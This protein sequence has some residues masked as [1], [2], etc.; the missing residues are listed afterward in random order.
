MT[1]IVIY[2][3]VP[4]LALF[5][6]WVVRTAKDGHPDV[7]GHERW[8]Y[9]Y[10]LAVIALIVFA[11][12]RVDVGTDYPMYE[13]FFR[14][15]DPTHFSYFFHNSPEEPGFTTGVLWLKMFFSSPQVLFLVTS[16][17]TVGC[18]ALA[19]RRLSVHFVASLTLFVLLG[20]YVAPFNILR[21]GLAVSLT[22]LAY[23]YM[24]KGKGRWLGLNVLA[25]LMH[26]SAILAAV[27]QVLLRRVRPTWFLYGAMLFV[28]VA[29]AVLVHVA[30]SAFSFLS[31][32]NDRYLSYLQDHPSGIGTYLY[33]LSRFILVALLLV[34]R[35]RNGEIDRYIVLAMVGVCLLI[36][37]T[38]AVAI[39]RLELYFSIYLVVALPRAARELPRPSR[40]L[41]ISGVMAMVTVFYIAYL[42]KFGNLVPYHFDWALVGLPSWVPGS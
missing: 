3:L 7:E 26:S 37:G 27:L 33:L 24:D 11:G 22:F 9:S 39:G 28:S 21:Q 15:V 13:S 19:I 25:A 20:F 35:P 4:L 18:A 16:L 29:L 31:I 14:Q 42:T 36:L 34:Y 30:P 23:S 10:I 2:L 41:V 12:A 32:F 8:R 5:P 17:V 1:G 6:A 38:Q 40:A